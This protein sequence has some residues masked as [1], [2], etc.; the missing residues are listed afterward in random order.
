MTDPLLVDVPERWLTERLILRCPRPGDGAMLNAAVCETL[1]EL[2]PW[3][4]WAQ[5]A[6]TP[7][8]SEALVRK[9]NAKFR[10]REDLVMFIL[11]R[12]PGDQ[13]GELLGG[14]G[15]H[16]INWAV[17]GFEIG[18]WRRRGRGGRGVVT[19]AVQGL[20]RMAFDVLQARRVEVRMDDLNVASWKVAE[21]AGFTLEGVLRRDSLTPAGQPRDTRVYARV[22]GVEER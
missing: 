13:E 17:R 21:R 10:L 6:P 20:A 12:L 16:R 7:E 8:E 22:R 19:E 9:S 1:D 11:E 2:K 3:M 14:S 15:L 18:Y 5:A 4:P